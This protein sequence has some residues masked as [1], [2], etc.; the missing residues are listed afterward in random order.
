MSSISCARSAYVDIKASRFHLNAA[1]A[2]A[3]G[4]RN[5]I[6]LFAVAMVAV[7]TL[8]GNLGVSRNYYADIEDRGFRLDIVRT[9]NDFLIEWASPAPDRFIPLANVPFWDPQ[10]A[11]AETAR[12]EPRAEAE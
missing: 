4:V 9:Y 2:S 8:Y 7:S 3:A 1:L 10:V 11:A 6:R 5:G 12:T